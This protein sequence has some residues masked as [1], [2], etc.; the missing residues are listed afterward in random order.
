[1]EIGFIEITGILTALY[2]VC[3][4]YFTMTFNFWKSRGVPGPEP[5]PLFGNAKDVIFSKLSVGSYVTTEYNKYKNHPMF[6]IFM[7]RDP[8]L[9][10]ND[11]EIIKEVLVKNF[12]TFPNRGNRLFEKVEPLTANLINLEA[13]R[14]RPLRAKQTTMFSSA[15]LK[16]MFYLILECAN[17]FEKILDEMIENNNNIIECCN[18]SAR[19]TTD[20]IGNCIF[21]IDMKALQDKDSEFCKVGLKFVNVNKWRAFKMRF[22]QVFM[23]DHEINDFFINSM[24][25]TMEYRKKNNIRRADFVDL[26]NELKD[27]SDQLKDIGKFINI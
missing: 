6:G 8:I 3:Y 1:M 18:V 16:D 15:K 2:L 26:L 11:P 13:S 4:Y 9:V 25:K 20:V 19:F 5:V 23:Y 12:S 7:S 17:N 24:I 27:N 22:K 10:L 14:W 21:G